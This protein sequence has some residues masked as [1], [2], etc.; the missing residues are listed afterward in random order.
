MLDAMTSDTQTSMQ[1]LQL[2]L[3]QLKNA[4]AAED[5]ALAQQIIS[6]HDQRLRA[7][8]NDRGSSLD[9]AALQGVLQEQHALTLMMCQLRDEAADHL[10]QERQSSRVASAYQQA[11]QLA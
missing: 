3:E 4:I 6:A 1:A 10:R 7:H 8:V 2:D 9:P 11:G 5:H